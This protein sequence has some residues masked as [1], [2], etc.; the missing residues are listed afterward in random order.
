MIKV[1]YFWLLGFYKISV[2][3]LCFILSTCIYNQTHGK[4][5]S[6]KFLGYLFPKF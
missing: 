4:K 2:S 6:L 5:T 3:S 1:I